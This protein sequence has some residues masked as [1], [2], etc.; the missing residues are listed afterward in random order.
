[1]ITYLR[2]KL[3]SSKNQI[4]NLWETLVSPFP[5][6]KKQDKLISSKNQIQNLL[7]AIYGIMFL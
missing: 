3:I 1:V 2:N 5:T 7:V 6:K 4:Q